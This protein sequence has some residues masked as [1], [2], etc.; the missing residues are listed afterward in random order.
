VPRMGLDNLIL[1]IEQV[2]KTAPDIYLV[3][4][5]EGPLKDDLISMVKK[6]GV[7]KH[8]EFKGF[9]SE[10]NLPE[11]YQM[12]DL[13]VLPTRELEGF[14]LVTLE[15]LAC[16]VPVL[17]TPVGGTKEI[18]GRF[19]PDFLFKDTAAASKFC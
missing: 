8:I 4:G 6:L 16:G 18:I 14:G 13:F 2:I 9:I 15:A 11:Y 3:V 19:D 10:D 12:T 1:A 7:E 17:G 5:G